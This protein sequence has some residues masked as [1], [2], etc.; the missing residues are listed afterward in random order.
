MACFLDPVIVLARITRPTAKAPPPVPCRALPRF[1]VAGSSRRS[2]SV[3]ARQRRTSAVELDQNVSSSGSSWMRRGRTPVRGKETADVVVRRW[4]VSEPS[5]RASSSSR[6]EQL[7]E[8]HSAPLWPPITRRPPRTSFALPCSSLGAA[9]PPCSNPSRLIFDL[10]RRYNHAA[11]TQRRAKET[12]TAEKTSGTIITQERPASEA[13]VQMPPS[14]GVHADTKT[15]Q[16]ADSSSGL[17]SRLTRSMSLLPSKDGEGNSNSSIAKLVDLARPEKQQLATAIGLLFISSGVSML[18]PLTIG[19]LIDFFASPTNETFFGLSFPVAAGALALT[20]C[21]GAAANA[22]RAILMRLSGQR[23]IARVRNQAYLSTL[24]QEPEFADKG[25]GDIVSRLSID[26]SIVGDSVTSNLSD[27]LRAIISA[28]VGVAAMVYI[29][30]KLTMVM[31]AVVPPVSI[32]AVIYGRYL[33]KLSN[34][35]QEALGDMSKTAE[36]KLNAFKTVAA[37]NAQSLEGSKFSHKVDKV[38]QLAKKEAIA[39]GIFFGG[40]G[41]TG[42]LT[43]LCLLGYGGHLVSRGE[44]TVGDLT[45]LLIYTGYVGGSVSGLTGF[46]T[47]LMKGVGAGT[48]VF[49]LLDRKSAI[50]LSVGKFCPKERNGPIRLENVSFTYPSRQE[51][52][53]LNGVNLNIEVGTSLAICGPSGSGKSSIQALLCRFYDPNE[54]R[55]LFD[56]EDIRDFTVESWR[57]RIGVVSQDPTLF[58]GTVHDNIAYGIPDTTRE[59][60]EEAARQAN[61]DFIWQ[62]PQGFDTQ[63][64]KA[65]LS[66]GQKQ[67]IAIARALVRKP[68][69]LLLDEATSALDSTSEHAVNSAIDHIIHS[70]QI[71]VILVAHR[72]SS[73]ARAERVVV[74]EAGKITEEGTYAELSRREGGRFRSLMAAQLALEKSKPNK[75]DTKQVEGDSTAGAPTEETIIV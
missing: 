20:F 7:R 71:T 56:G 24:K 5:S 19:K 39:S 13:V 36:E 60:V 54:G 21:V 12:G 46:W 34:Q 49:D 8:S 65:S 62:L 30:A 72:L 1:N 57:S 17:I 42:N 68:S 18:V 22:G 66:G 73:I 53:V 63:I 9:F 23:I 69:I 59:D 37:F 75:A 41:L 61:C 74:L 2:L 32:G 35:T 45:S 40:S 15:A 55:V 48:R 43:M 16:Q 3:D 52:G 10:S 25:A 28:V 14:S 26:T 11:A 27:G 44:I 29:S 33:R 50:P 4:Y 31:L 47:G 64:G 51:V 67:R 38:F 6:K 58:T 70:Q